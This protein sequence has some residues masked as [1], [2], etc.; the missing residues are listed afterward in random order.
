[1]DTFIDT[2]SALGT[3]TNALDKILL[4][5]LGLAL[6]YFLSNSLLVAVVIALSSNDGVFKVWYQNYLS[7]SIDFLVS[8]CGAAL[9]VYLSNFNAYLPLL[10]APFLGAVWGIN[11]INHAKAL[12]AQHH[13]KDQEQL[14]L[15]TVESLALAVDAKDQTTYG[16]I[17]R[18]RAYALGLARLCGITE[19]NELMAIE[20]GSLLHDIGKLAIDDYI[21][22]K[23]GRLT[24]Q[25][26]EKMKVHSTAGDEILQQIQFPF[27]VAKY[28]RYHHERWDG[29]G[30]PDGLKESQ[31]PL[32][33]RILAVADA[34]DAI[35]SSRPYKTSFGIQDS[36]ELLKAQSG[37]LY[38]PAI[39]TLLAENID[40][41]ES[42]ASS[43]VQNIPELT[44]RKY[45]E[46]ADQAILTASSSP[47]ILP[48]ETSSE[49]ISCFEFCTTIGRQLNLDDLFPIL[50]RRLR[51]LIPFT[52]CAY[53]LDDGSGFIKAVYAEGHCA[54]LIKDLSIG[55]GKGISGWVSAYKRPIV[56]THPALEFGSI[57]QP[58]LDEFTDILA[59]PLVSDSISIGTITLYAKAPISYS[60]THV[61]LMQTLG[62]QVA[63][64]LDS[65]RRKSDADDGMRLIDPI[66]RTHRATYL[67]VAG[68]TLLASAEKSQSPM[69]LL[70]ITI[71]NLNQIVTLY[72]AEVANLVLKKV[73]ETI[74]SELR[75]TDVLV[76]YGYQ[77]F[78]ALLPGVKSEQAARYNQ[79]LQSQIRSTNTSN[80][81]GHNILIHSQGA[82]ACYPQDGSTIISLLQSVNTTLHETNPTDERESR[83]LEFPPRLKE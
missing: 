74:Q 60:E 3:A 33:A 66:T 35:R 80:S 73:S 83:I 13:L 63:A 29:T 45:F 72:G 24:T 48:R 65:V 67:S 21:L 26:F 20:T 59:I 57:K 71:K 50:T 16:H 7:L 47:E 69:C 30:Y 52:T 75:Q 34:F 23:P 46:K 54:N 51:V 11:K 25:E 9:M 55:L 10:I 5:T 18:V 38:D 62:G 44:F 31:I 64:L 12:E 2:F 82:I 42:D 79:R 81:M 40:R 6:T 77:S 76:R 22:N 70:C 19:N 39:V 1:M 28:V 8:A 17:R 68:A 61:A 56:N 37:T 32:G 27:P 14:Y 58:G 15:R 49:L 53:Y 41:L 4:P 36:L 43:A 78:I